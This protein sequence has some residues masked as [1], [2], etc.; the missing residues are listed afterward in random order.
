MATAER[1]PD[2]Y[3]RL[4]AARY[5][6]GLIV[7]LMAMRP[8]RIAN[9]TAIVM[10]GHLV[11]VGEGYRLCFPAV[12]TKN[13]A[14]IEVPFPDALIPRLRRYIEHY[15]PVLLG[16]K[17]SDRL[18]ISTRGSGLSEQAVYQQVCTVTRTMATPSTPISFATAPQPRS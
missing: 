12:E 13:N 16:D 8:F 6:D 17:T 14:D 11:A 4:R 1:D 3:P 15:R 9:F 2:F 7:A 18:W 10:G 5:R